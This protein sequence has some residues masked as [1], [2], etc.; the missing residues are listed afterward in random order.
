MTVLRTTDCDNYIEYMGR[1]S[2]YLW[3]HSDGDVSNNGVYT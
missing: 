2:I 3:M 1:G